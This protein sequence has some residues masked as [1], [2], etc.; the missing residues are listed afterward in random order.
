M[1]PLQVAKPRDAGLN[2]ER[3]HIAALCG[4]PPSECVVLCAERSDAGLRCTDPRNAPT[5]TFEVAPWIVA[6]HS[7]I[8]RT[9]ATVGGRVRF[10]R[11][12]SH[13]R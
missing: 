3:Q 6:S 9:L 13:E 1:T 7:T 4:S 11:R 5:D 2:Q 8:Y 12:K 10:Y